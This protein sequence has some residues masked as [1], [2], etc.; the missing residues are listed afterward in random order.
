MNNGMKNK[1]LKTVLSLLA[2]SV[3]MF[4]CSK[5][6]EPDDKNKIDIKGTMTNGDMRS[7]NME[8]YMAGNTVWVY[9]YEDFGDCTISITSRDSTLV[10]CET[11]ST[12][13]DAS[14]RYYMGDE[15]LSRYHL[16]ISNGTDEAEG[17]FFNFRFA[18]VRPKQ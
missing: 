10:T 1:Y 16:V 9:F 4:S 8:A 18:A 5:T 2:L 3:L 12:Y 15:P 11:I 17:W 14:W 6:M 7:P 13:E